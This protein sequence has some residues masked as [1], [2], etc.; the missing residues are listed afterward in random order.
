M[1]SRRFVSTLALLLAGWASPAAAGNDLKADFTATVINVL[2]DAGGAVVIGDAVD[3]SFTVD[4][5]AEKIELTPVTQGI[6]PYAVSKF[7]MKFAS[8]KVKYSTSANDVPSFEPWLVMFNNQDF[9]HNGGDEFAFFFDPVGDAIQGAEPTR[10]S[11]GLVDITGTLYDTTD[12]PASL[13]LADFDVAYV[14]VQ[15]GG[16]WYEPGGVSVV[17]YLDTLNVK[18]Q[19]E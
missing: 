3:G 17:T 9:I 11:F 19:C 15:Y 6:Y 7:D 10:V 16:G 13:D 1:A 8:Q 2:G 18:S 12:L 4:C 5:E 14:F